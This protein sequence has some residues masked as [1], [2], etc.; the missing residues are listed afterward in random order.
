MGESQAFKDAVK[1]LPADNGVL[2]LIDVPQ[3]SEL[4]A[5]SVVGLE[6]A[7]RCVNPHSTRV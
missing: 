2:A 5:K 6:F 1:H 4:M 7:A 3:Y